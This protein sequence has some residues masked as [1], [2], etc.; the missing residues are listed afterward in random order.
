M[1][2]RVG[3][4]S[5]VFKQT[6]SSYLNKVGVKGKERVGTYNWIQLIPNHLTNLENHSIK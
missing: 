2:G 3:V 1:V 6:L 5:E 4:V